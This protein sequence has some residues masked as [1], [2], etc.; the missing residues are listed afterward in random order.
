[1]ELKTSYERRAY[2]SVD[3]ESLSNSISQNLTGKMFQAVM[4]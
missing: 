4:G 1:M 2:E 3:D